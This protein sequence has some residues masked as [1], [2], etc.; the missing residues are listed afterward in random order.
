MSN[1][2]GNG[3]VPHDGSPQ[4]LVVKLGANG[5]AD[6]PV[7]RALAHE[8]PGVLHL[9]VSVQV[10]DVACGG[11]LL[12][13]RAAAKAVFANRWANTCCTHPAPG[14]D[15]AGAALRRL[16]Q[17][18]GLVVEDL[19][20]AGSFIYRAID[21]QSR[22]VEHEHDFVFV[23]LADIG[24]VEPDPDEISALALLP[25]EQAVRLLQSEDG[26]PWAATVLEQ[27]CAA[28][29]FDGLAEPG[30]VGSRRRR[31]R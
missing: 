3:A 17:E 18:T 30:S 21:P 10:V 7:D 27:S 31:W 29:G 16:R 5:L 11:W 1:V 13:R 9:A 2:Q 22:L 26:A 4:R 14:E 28:L 19:L 24:A 8:P 12:Q 6:V 25:F 23:A 15:P 20:A